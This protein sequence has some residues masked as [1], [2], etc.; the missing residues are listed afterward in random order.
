MKTLTHNGTTYRIVFFYPHKHSKKRAVVGCRVT[1]RTCSPD[2]GE[3]VAGPDY[4]GTASCNRD[5]GD[6]FQKELGR[7]LALERAVADLPH[8]LRPKIRALY[9]HRTLGTGG[10]NV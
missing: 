4:V 9:H 8:D 2:S 5:S 3:L 10:G 1:T 7:V 6:E